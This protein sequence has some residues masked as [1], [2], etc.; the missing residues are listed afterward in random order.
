MFCVPS[1]WNTL[2]KNKLFFKTMWATDN[3]FRRY[4][5]VA[6]KMAKSNTKKR[7]HVH[8]LRISQVHYSFTCN[9]ELWMIHISFF[10]FGFHTK[11]KYQKS[12]GGLDPQD[13][14][15]GTLFKMC[16]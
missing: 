11:I 7:K 3:S 14:K 15:S 8:C 12:I 2:A 6:G 16:G 13:T 10:A 1:L 5:Q 4:I 9:F